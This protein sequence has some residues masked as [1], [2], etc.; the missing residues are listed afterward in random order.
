MYVCI[1]VV[2]PEMT[3]ISKRDILKLT[4]FRLY[5]IDQLDCDYSSKADEAKL[6]TANG[7]CLLSQPLNCSIWFN[8]FKFSASKCNCW[9]SRDQVQCGKVFYYCNQIRKRVVNNHQRSQWTLRC[10]SKEYAGHW[11]WMHNLWENAVMQQS[12]GA[13][14]YA[15]VWVF[16]TSHHF[17][18]A[19]NGLIIVIN[20]DEK[21]TSK[22]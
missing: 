2:N 19:R 17:T 8:W 14:I 13:G 3:L 22:L 9:S 5:N 6:P 7:S 21:L 11:K 20:C 10:W 15:Y 1:W 12:G 16:W 18:R 4:G